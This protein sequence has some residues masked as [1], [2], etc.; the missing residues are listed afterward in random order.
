MSLINIINRCLSEFEIQNIEKIKQ[1][2]VMA[3]QNEIRL[4]Y[5]DPYLNDGEKFYQ[6]NRVRQIEDELLKRQEQYMFLSGALSFLT[7]LS[8]RY[9][10][11]ANNKTL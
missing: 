9:E 1:E 5:A 3:T 2:I 8:Q 4:I 11:N 10:K 6:E 7:Q